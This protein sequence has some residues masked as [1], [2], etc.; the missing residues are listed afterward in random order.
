[1]NDDPSIWREIFSPL[2]GALAFFGG[3]GGLVKALAIKTT[4]KETLRVTVIGAATAFGLGTLAPYMLAWVLGP[5]VE[6]PNEIKSALG[7]LC[8][9][10]FIFGLIATAFVERVIAKAEGKDNVGET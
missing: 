5:G 7:P 10:A 3:L 6:I 9:T 8:A 2:A 4:W 1:M